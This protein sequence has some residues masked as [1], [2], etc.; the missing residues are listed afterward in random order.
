MLARVRR[1]RPVIGADNVEV[2]AGGDG[3]AMGVWVIV[4]AGGAARRLGGADKP[5]LTVAG[6]SLL[7]GVLDRAAGLDPAGIVVV[8]PHRPTSA[9]VR[10]AREQPPGGGPLAALAAGLAAVPAPRTAPDSST[11]SGAAQDVPAPAGSGADTAVGAAEVVVLAADLAGLRPD[12]L[13]RLVTVL[14]GSPSV[15][16]AV[17]HDE[18]GRPQWLCG[19]WRAGPLRA[20]LPADP[21]GRS[22]R[23]VLTTLAVRAVRGRP[24]ESAD[25]D[26][27]ADLARARQTG[28]SSQASHR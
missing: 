6:R 1:A 10:W 23:S 22:L 24:G 16:G 4:L 7:D 5:A 19:V 9:A 18:T 27:P 14:S 21:A 3:T 13:P 28:P 15:D 25:V 17:L 11:D 12:T 2:A 20:A 8:G 26:T